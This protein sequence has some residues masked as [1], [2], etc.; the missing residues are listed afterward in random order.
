MADKL[1]GKT[2]PQIIAVEPASCPS[3]T[4]GK[5]RYDFCDTGKICPQA[6]M[7]TLGC[8]FMPSANH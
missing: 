7:Y 3:L 8:D 6:K 5:Y 1:Q 2:N 4:R